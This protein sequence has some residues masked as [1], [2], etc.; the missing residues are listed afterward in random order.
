LIA[1][2]AICKD[3]STDNKNSEH[4][5]ERRKL[6]LAPGFSLKVLKV[7][8]RLYSDRKRE[9]GN[10]KGYE[11]VERTKGGEEGSPFR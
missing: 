5:E 3:A 2:P 4:S 7:S 9:K 10:D 6:G 1:P 11:R 8:E